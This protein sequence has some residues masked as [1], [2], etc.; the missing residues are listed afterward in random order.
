[1][2]T[3]IFAQLWEKIMP[4]PI[5]KM[6]LSTQHNYGLDHV[7]P[8]FSLE[9]RLAQEDHPGSN[10]A[11]SSICFSTG[12]LDVKN[13]RRG[14]VAYHFP[15]FHTSSSV[16]SSVPS[17]FLN[18]RSRNK[19]SGRGNLEDGGRQRQPESQPTA[20][21]TC[22]SW[23]HTW[24]GLVWST[25]RRQAYLVTIGMDGDGFSIAL[26]SY[27]LHLHLLHVDTSMADPHTYTEARWREH[28][29]R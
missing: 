9:S 24:V 17:S 14:Y 12:T 20:W 1:M 4:L 5:P 23:P 18:S 21:G 7:L 19:K 29:L 10:A 26:T 11:P 3:N 25:A 28:F 27:V 2:K 6:C 8:F 15:V 13:H 16:L 22:L